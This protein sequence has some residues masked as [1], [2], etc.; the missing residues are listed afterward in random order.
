VLVVLDT[1]RADHV[2]AYGYPRPTTPRLDALAAEGVLFEHAVSA[3]PWTAASVATL[4]TGLSPSVHGVD[5]GPE[6]VEPEGADG[7]PFRRQKVLG[8]AHRT[9][10]E[11][12]GAAGYHTA[13][14]V[15]NVFVHSIFGFAQGFDVYDDDHRDYAGDF[16]S[17][18]RRGRDTNERIFAWLDGAAANDPERP[19]LLVAHYNDAH[20][21]YDP[22]APYGEA[23]TA[24]YPGDVRPEQTGFLVERA[25]QPLGAVPVNDMKYVV[26]LYD[27]ELQYLDAVVGALIDRL[28]RVSNGRDL[29]VIVTADH[30]EEF[31]DH[32]ATS[33]GYT[34]FG[35]QLRVPLIV[36]APARVAPRRVDTL[37]RGVDLL[38]TVFELAGVPLAAHEVEGRSLVP[39]LRGEPLPGRPAFG[40]ATLAGGPAQHRWS[41]REGD[42]KLIASGAEE[43][44]GLRLFDLAADPRERRALPAPHP[45]RERLL[46]AARAWRQRGAE[47]AAR[48][49]G[50]A[51]IEL[52][53]DTL[54]RLQALGYALDEAPPAP[55]APPERPGAEGPAPPPTAAPAAPAGD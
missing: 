43:G 26:G 44:G 12:L 39:L 25:G 20:W 28:A 41:V 40:E 31:L 3:A 54:E 29:V 5:E 51:E 10:A 32:G 21:P 33:H 55:T 24:G 8:D 45:G 18:K 22:P 27:G 9:L 35:E 17:A 7:L 1:V 42:L 4:F 34:L 37:V 50:A 53:G 14:F 38:P 15:S 16:V 47:L 48:V 46:A 52:E 19:F 36:H 23:F 2:G 49:G 30:G 13:A 6:M 11:G